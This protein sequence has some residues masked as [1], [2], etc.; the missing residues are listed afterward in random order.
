M[1]QLTVY[2]KKKEKT[3]NQ[4]EHLI[5]SGRHR[6]SCHFPSSVVFLLSSLLFAFLQFFLLLSFSLFYF[7][8]VNAAVSKCQSSALCTSEQLWNINEPRGEREPHLDVCSHGKSALRREKGSRVKGIAAACVILMINQRRNL[9]SF[10]IRPILCTVSLQSS[11]RSLLFRK[12]ALKM[13]RRPKNPGVLSFG[14]LLINNLLHS[15][16]LFCFFGVFWTRSSGE[17]SS[18]AL[19]H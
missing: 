7:I 5:T 15:V 14:S 19:T 3:T 6:A 8:T 11:S 9:F 10:S 12:L 18:L 1:Y 13:A 17:R 16:G 2:K 4:K